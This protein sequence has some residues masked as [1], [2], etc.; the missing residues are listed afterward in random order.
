MKL[1]SDLQA[2]SK[3]PLSATKGSLNRNLVSTRL[4]Q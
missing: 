2:S 3:Y 1:R 4:H